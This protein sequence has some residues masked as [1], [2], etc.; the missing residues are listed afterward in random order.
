VRVW[1]SC[2]LVA[3]RKKGIYHAEFDALVKRNGGKKIPAVVAIGRKLLRLMFSVARSK[4]AFTPEPPG[5][6]PKIVA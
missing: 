3:I 4:R 1:L 5:M 2:F 6:Q